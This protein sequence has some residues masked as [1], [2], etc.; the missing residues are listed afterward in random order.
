MILILLGQ[1][2]SRRGIKRIAYRSRKYWL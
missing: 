1:K 2:Q